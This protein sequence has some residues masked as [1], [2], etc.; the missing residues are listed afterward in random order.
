MIPDRYNWVDYIRKFAAT[1]LFLKG[2]F[3]LGQWVLEYNEDLK[4]EL[5]KSSL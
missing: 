5:I 4:Y 2:Y 3:E 1:M